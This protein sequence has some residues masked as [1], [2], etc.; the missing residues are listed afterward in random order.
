MVAT[1]EF[2]E[3]NGAAPGT[4]GSVGNLNMGNIDSKELTPASN[5][6][7]AGNN[8]YEKYVVGSWA[9]TFTQ[10]DNVQFWMSAGSFGTGESIDWS[11]SVTA[12]ADP[13]ATTST[14]ATTA[15]PTSDPGTANVTIGSSLSGT[16]SAAGRSDY[17]VLQ[18]Q[19]TVSADPGPTNQKTFTIQWDEQ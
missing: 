12:Y 9:G 15:I 7:T 17:I 16:L 14:V 3:A 2:H 13:V 4:L 19:T 5:P 11:G 10:I 8:S 1:F 18:Y 6:I